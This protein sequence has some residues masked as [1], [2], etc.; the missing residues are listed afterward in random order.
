MVFFKMSAFDDWACVSVKDCESV[1]VGRQIDVISDYWCNFAKYD[2]NDLKR[3]RE[4]KKKQV[5]MFCVEPKIVYNNYT[6]SLVEH[7]AYNIC[8]CLLALTPSLPPSLSPTPV[9]LSA[10]TLTRNSY[11]KIWQSGSRSKLKCKMSSERLRLWEYWIG[12]RGTVIEMGG[13]ANEH[14]GV[15]FLTDRYENRHCTEGSNYA[16]LSTEEISNRLIKAI[17]TKVDTSD[18]STKHRK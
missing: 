1:K 13:T 4:N 16:I 12:Q 8:L 6:R 18:M 11:W 9:P 7:T 17:Y 2:V 15:R 10:C 14:T 5:R 3:C